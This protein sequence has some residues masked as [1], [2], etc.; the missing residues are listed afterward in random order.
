MKPATGRQ[1]E[2]YRFGQFEFDE[3][4][5]RLW[6]NGLAVRLQW[7]PGRVLGMLVAA[8]G[9]VVSREELQNALWPEDS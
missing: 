5:V 1:P 6:R 8:N 2:R 4:T 9:E 7:Q 3:A